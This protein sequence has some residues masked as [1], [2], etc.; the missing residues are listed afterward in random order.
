MKVSNR[1]II[2]VN[3]PKKTGKYPDYKY[4][5]DVTVE[6]E[7]LF[8]NMKKTKRCGFKMLPELYSC[9]DLYD[10][11]DIFETRRCY[12]VVKEA[13]KNIKSE[14]EC[15][16][17]PD[18]EVCKEVKVRNIVIELIRKRN[19]WEYLKTGTKVHTGLIGEIEYN[20]FY[21]KYKDYTCEFETPVNTLKR[22]ACLNCGFIDDTE[23]QNMIKYFNSFLDRE[24]EKYKRQLKAK[25]IC[26]LYNKDTLT[27]EGKDE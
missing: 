23:K 24:E 13:C 1:R 26:S 5:A 9:F 11:F 15:C 14:D 27:T 10:G 18:F 21:L 3:N 8:K 7:G 19:N 12:L 2:D 16:I 6:T 22:F 4:E 20:V 17:E 25:E